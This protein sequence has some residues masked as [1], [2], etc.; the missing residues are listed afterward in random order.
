LTAGCTP[1]RVD[2]KLSFTLR[3]SE[4]EHQEGKRGTQIRMEGF[5]PV[6]L[7]G[8]PRL[9]RRVYQ[10]LL[11]PDVDPASVSVEVTGSQESVRRG[12]GRVEAASPIAELGEKNKTREVPRADGIEL[13]DGKNPHLYGQNVDFP[14]S[15]VGQVFVSTYRGW[16][17]LNIP[18]T[19]VRYND[20]KAVLTVASEM[21]LVIE[22]QEFEIPVDSVVDDLDIR[23]MV[24][25][26]GL[27]VWDDIEREYDVTP[28]D[29][30]D[31]S[32]PNFLIVTTQ[33]I[34]DEGDENGLNDFVAH[35]ERLGF[36]VRVKT[37]EEI[38][39]LYSSGDT[40]R[41]I[42]HLIQ[43][44]HDDYD[45]EYVLLVG[46]PDPNADS[47]TAAEA[48]P[49]V[50][51]M[52]L[53][54]PDGENAVTDMY[55]AEV[56]ADWDTDDDGKYSESWVGTGCPDIMVGRIAPV[57]GYIDD[58]Y[59]GD[60]AFTE[61]SR[62]EKLRSVFEKMIRYDTEIDKSW[63]YGMLV[64]GSWIFGADKG[65]SADQ[66]HQLIADIHNDHSSFSA[67]TLFQDGTPFGLDDEFFDGV[68]NP[69]A[70]AYLVGMD[71]LGIHS[72]TAY[73]TWSQNGPS[74]IIAWSGHGSYQSVSV[75]GDNYGCSTEDGWALFRWWFTE[76]DNYSGYRID[77]EKPALVYSMSCSNF[78]TG[79][80]KS[81]EGDASGQRTRW[82]S[83]A[84][85]LQ[86]QG[87]IGVVAATGS[88]Y[89]ET[90]L[91]DYPTTGYGPWYQNRFLRRVTDGET[92]GHAFMKMKQTAHA[93]YGGSGSDH[94]SKL[95]TW[96]RVNL[97][98]DPSQQL[99]QSTSDLPDDEY[100]DGDGNDT[101]ENATVLYT[102]IRPSLIPRNV[103]VEVTGAVSKDGDCYVLRN[104][105]SDAK[106]VRI[107]LTR[108]E[109]LG[110]LDLEV[111]NEDGEA[112][113]G[114][115]TS[116]ANYRTF[117]SS[118]TTSSDTVY[119]RV[120]AGTHVNSYD[121]K[122]TIDR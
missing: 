63:R 67:Y 27:Q 113:R 30:D 70:D 81:V 46:N 57:G 92:F 116:F 37:V 69:E 25:E 60:T 14:A 75:G 21:E 71:S 28:E 121:L 42:R 52:R 12:V 91:P 110:D 48:D 3:F 97:L 19:P 112:I 65:N 31:S 108:N 118:R 117:L 47:S 114:R 35:K 53:C 99:F 61:V 58:I 105:G 39:S 103:V 24:V 45:L 7:A 98:A 33:T 89:A 122:V 23:R 51:P 120:K 111:V 9:P 34:E 26:N 109:R 62:E 86:Y 8:N 56:D 104:L 29:P 80:A 41:K 13:I 54:S 93:A 11:P 119:V 74:G 82:A 40:P 18:V 68:S 102:E 43:D 85:V 50:V 84:Q 94:K 66:L 106:T 22:Y 2:Q 5:E 72:S 76:P 44:Y 100:D 78:S 38:E 16:K 49:G 10:I 87:A 64:F 6:G 73:Y 4:L 83:L 36:N 96:L 107:R 15:P 1:K 115:Q 90:A 88:Q 20:S 101:Y 79:Y 95:K 17:I 55:Y 59:S 77:D 32:T